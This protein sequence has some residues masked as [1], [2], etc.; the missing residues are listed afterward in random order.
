[1]IT[2]IFYFL[3]A[4]SNEVEEGLSVYRPITRTPCGIHPVKPVPR[5]P[6]VGYRCQ[7]LFSKASQAVKV[8]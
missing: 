4:S 3:G 1:M 7:C 5:C 6:I 2:V 8:M